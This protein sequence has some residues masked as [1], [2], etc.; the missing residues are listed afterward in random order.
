MILLDSFHVLLLPVA[1]SFKPRSLKFLKFQSFS[2]ISSTK[3]SF[4]VLL[5]QQIILI[6]IIFFDHFSLSI[7]KILTRVRKNHG[8][9]I[10]AKE[11]VCHSFMI[12][13]CAITKLM[14]VLALLWASWPSWMCSRFILKTLSH[15]RDIKIISMTRTVKI[16]GRVQIAPVIGFWGGIMDFR[17]NRS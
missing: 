13:P 2:I 4:W 12:S 5:V 1:H 9:L 16:E 6:V 7:I 15:A 10:A 17:M 14:I 3:W 8:L 11:S